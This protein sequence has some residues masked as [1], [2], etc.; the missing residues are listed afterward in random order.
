[1][2]IIT[3]EILEDHELPEATSPDDVSEGADDLGMVAAVRA[4]RTMINSEN[5]SVE[6]T[7]PVKQ[8][9]P[10]NITEATPTSRQPLGDVSNSNTVISAQGTA[11][12]AAD[13][14]VGTESADPVTKINE[15]DNELPVGEDDSEGIPGDVGDDV[16][17]EEMDAEGEADDDGTPPEKPCEA[18]ARSDAVKGTK[19]KRE[20]GK[21]AIDWGVSDG[22]G[23]NQAKRNKKLEYLATLYT[24]YSTAKKWPNMLTTVKLAKSIGITGNYDIL[25][26]VQRKSYVS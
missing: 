5:A 21:R 11:G 19:S 2:D 1:M 14:G 12:Q 7:P 9:P 10:P 18:V 16:G 23:E 8:K 13:A 3:D 15:A 17:V 22:V 26:E 25:T 20:N 24:Y 4:A 6:H